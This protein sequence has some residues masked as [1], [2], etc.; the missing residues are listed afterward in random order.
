MKLLL[1]IYNGPTPDRVSALLEMHGA[2]GY[3]QVTHAHGV[4]STGRAEGT[5]AWP[6]DT[7]VF[8]TVVPDERAAALRSAVRAFHDHTDGG[9]RL[10][11]ATMPLEDFE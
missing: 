5:R 7:T 9:E 2:S 4:G 6:G 3:T 11:V 8:F 10:H 1:L